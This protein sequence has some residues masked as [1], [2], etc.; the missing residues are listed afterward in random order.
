M[1][2]LRLG[3]FPEDSGSLSSWRSNLTG[4][5]YG[6][7]DLK[8]LSASSAAARVQLGYLAE[9]LHAHKFFGPAQSIRD[10]LAGKFSSLDEAFGLVVP[11]KRRGAPADPDRGLLIAR[12]IDPLKRE[13]KTWESIEEALDKPDFI[14]RGMTVRQLRKIYETHFDVNAGGV[15][16]WLRT[17]KEMIAI[18]EEV[19][20]R[21]KGKNSSVAPAPSST[22]RKSKH[23]RLKKSKSV[24]RRSAG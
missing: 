15:P 8:R 5:G 11:P 17:S 20:R 24:K 4:Q 14:G 10:F 12:E 1:R 18:S 23:S 19:V 7:D 21:L 13:G 16:D 22:P 9:S 3:R 2:A 6:S